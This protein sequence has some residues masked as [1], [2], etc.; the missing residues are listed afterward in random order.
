MLLASEAGLSSMMLLELDTI[1]IFN[2][3]FAAAD[4]AHFVGFVFV[5]TAFVCHCRR[6]KFFLNKK[7]IIKRK[8]A[9]ILMVMSPQNEIKKKSCTE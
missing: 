5:V 1:I 9:A 8:S 4:A 6:D 3:V 7:N 2:V